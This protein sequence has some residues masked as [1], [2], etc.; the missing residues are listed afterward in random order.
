[1]MQDNS[2]ATLSYR[3]QANGQQE[4]S[5]KTMIQTVRVYV[6]DPLQAD[7]DDLAEKLVHAI[8]NSR[9]STRKE[10]PFY[11]I[12][13]WDAHSTLKARTESMQLAKPRNK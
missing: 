3:P 12:H 1:M 5:V 9:D 10:T 7:W 13:G 4:Q 2:R 11:L 8:N 6:G